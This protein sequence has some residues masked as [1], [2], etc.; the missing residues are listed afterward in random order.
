MLDTIAGLTLTALVSESK[1]Y[2]RYELDP[3]NKI[4]VKAWQADT[5][6]RNFDVGKPAASMRHTFVKLNG[7]D[8]IYHARDNFRSKFDQNINDLRDKLI[9]SFTGSDIQEISVAKDQQSANFTRIQ[10]AVDEKPA[11]GQK[12]EGASAAP[13]KKTIWQSADGKPAEQGALNQLLADLSSLR[14]DS[15]IDDKNKADFTA[16]VYTVRLKGSQ[17]HD[18]FIFAKL[19]DEDTT[20]PAT[21][22]A[23]DYPFN[24]SA[25]KA[26]RIMKNP[27]EMFQKEQKKEEKTKPQKVDS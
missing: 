9:L 1:A 17:S 14:C 16:P 7:D 13:P 22:S 15:F 19:K 8:R 11:D 6:Q 5:L 10:Q 12:T 20:Y 3:K 21:S 24:L 27:E 2:I 18:L 4:S 25:S 23:S 26:E